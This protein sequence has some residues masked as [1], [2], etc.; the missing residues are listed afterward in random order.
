[1]TVL[2]MSENM[3][4]LVQGTEEFNG[5][6]YVVVKTND[7]STVR[8]QADGI[9]VPVYLVAD[10]PIHISS[11]TASAHRVNVNYSSKNICVS[12]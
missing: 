3:S 7:G 8:V 10:S 11:S 1:M 6:D 4:G 12:G 9:N 2:E 5:Q